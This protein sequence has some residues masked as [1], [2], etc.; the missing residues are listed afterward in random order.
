ML[1]DTEVSRYVDKLRTGPAPLSTGNPEG[2]F[3]LA[4]GRRRLSSSLA[5]GVWAKP[6]DGIDSQHAL[7]SVLP[8]TAAAGAKC[9]F[10]ISEDML[11]PLFEL[12]KRDEPEGRPGNRPI[13]SGVAGP[14]HE[15]YEDCLDEAQVIMAIVRA[16]LRHYRALGQ[17]PR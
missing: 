10:S 2:L 7:C 6:G 17:F 3:M 5:G 1:D 4:A 13:R 14:W 15:A 9:H 16:L 8:C 12:G 11:V